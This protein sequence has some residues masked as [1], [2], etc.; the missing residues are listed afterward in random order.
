[1]EGVLKDESRADRYTHME[2]GNGFISLFNTKHTYTV[3][4][5]EK[6]VQ[7]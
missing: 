5:L 4:M 1:M 6:H 7:G 2:C 3:T